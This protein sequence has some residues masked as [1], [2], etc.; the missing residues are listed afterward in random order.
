MYYASG[1]LADRVSKDLGKMRTD[2]GAAMKMTGN[3]KVI[4][5]IQT[6]SQPEQN[7]VEGISGTYCFDVDQIIGASEV[8][9]KTGNGNYA[10]FCW[11]NGFTTNMRNEPKYQRLAKQLANQAGKGAVYKTEPIIFGG[12]GSVYQRSLHDILAVTAR[13]D[14]EN[15][16]DGWLGGGAWPVRLITGAS[17]TPTRTTTAGVNI[18]GIGFRNPFSRL[19]TTKNL[20]NY[21]T[22]FAVFENYGP[23]LTKPASFNIYSTPDGGYTNTIRYSTGVTA[24]TPFRFSSLTTNSF[25]GI[26]EDAVFDLSVATVDAQANYRRFV[27]GLFVSTNW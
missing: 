16:T 19:V 12:I 22:G 3:A 25:D 15:S 4:P 13:K 9:G 26:G 17:E 24:G 1:T 23:S 20:L 11:D 18:A 21:F 8:F 2:F 5:C 14:P 7:P 27:Y 10:A 6:F